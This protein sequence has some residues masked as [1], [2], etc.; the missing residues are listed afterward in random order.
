MENVQ[1]GDYFV[2]KALDHGVQVIG[3]TRGQDTRFHHTEKLDKGEVII[4]QFTDHTSAVKIRGK[5]EIITKHGKI[6]SGS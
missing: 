6:E 3:L 5:A 4:A 2:V 1:N